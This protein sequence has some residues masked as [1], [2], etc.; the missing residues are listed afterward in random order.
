MSVFYRLG[1]NLYINITNRC[2]C[3]C[4]FCIR[5]ITHTVGDAPSLWLDSEPTV[6]ETIAEF[7]HQD[8]R[9][10]QEVVFCGYG[11]PMARAFDVLDIAKHI[12]ASCSLPL[13]LNTNGLVG[14]LHPSFDISNLAV[15]HTVSI[16][17][18]APNAQEYVALCQPEHGAIAY[19]SLLKFAQEIRP[20]TNV[21]LTV[22][23]TLAPQSIEKCRSIAAYIGVPLIVREIW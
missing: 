2:P 21:Q 1:K 7:N 19:D 20:Y 18:N 23:A 3:N 9:H 5:N 13:R 8:L 15:F 6:Q 14:M 16:S 4:I 22:M 12:A 10:V 17:L 11:E